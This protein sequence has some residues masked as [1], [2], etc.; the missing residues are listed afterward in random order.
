MNARS[1]YANIEVAINWKSD[2]ADHAEHH[3]YQGINFWRDFFP[4]MLG[5]KLANSPDG[6]WV[7]ESFAA[8]ELV[9]P[10]SGS[11]L[12]KVGKHR[13]MPI[14]KA[15]IVVTPY[16]G[17]FFPRSI[18]AGTAGI[19]Q[20]QYQPL[21]VLEVDE[22][23]MQVDLNHPLAQ[24]EV[25]VSIR[26]IGER[27][28]GKEERGG[29][30]NDVVY[31]FMHAGPG[32]QARVNGGTD[33]YAPQG[34]ERVDEAADEQFYQA[35]RL[36]GHIDREASAQ[37]AAYYSDHL[38]PG[39]KV[40]DFMASWQSHLPDIDDLHVTGLGMNAHEMQENPQ[41]DQHVVQDVNQNP[42]L[43]FD[44]GQ[45]DA[46]ICNLSVEYLTDPLTVFRELARITRK[47]GQIHM[48]VSDRWFPPKA[49][50][51]WSELHPFERLGLVLDYFLRTDGLDDLQTVTLQGLLR[52]EDDK[53]AN[54]RLYS[55]PLFIVR[56]T[57]NH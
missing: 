46:V 2:Q 11:N 26:V 53:H 23:S 32:M 1:D 38:K 34:F 24:H 40:L 39:M 57:V 41:I 10:Y 50:I 52:P 31:E 25:E 48:A 49:I 14:G 42:V 29:R 18:L 15:K 47:G 51:L 21:R 22:D 6:E 7:S 12:I 54:Q 56:A 5:E 8:G 13:I 19:L 16:K 28:I 43:P 36:I 30:C 44:D 9:E 35:D 4:G 27:Y 45:F 20:S 17:R 55:D 33:F 3:H 37:L